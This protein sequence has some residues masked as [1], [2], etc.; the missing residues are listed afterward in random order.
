[1][2]SWRPSEEHERFHIDSGPRISALQVVSEALDIQQQDEDDCHDVESVKTAATTASSPPTS[3]FS[4]SPPSAAPPAATTGTKTIVASDS[5][6]S[7]GFVKSGRSL[8]YVFEAS[9]SGRFQNIRIE[10][11]S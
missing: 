7:N 11:N 9:E 5:D 8:P 10:C 3:S 4:S 2:S 6:V 1:M